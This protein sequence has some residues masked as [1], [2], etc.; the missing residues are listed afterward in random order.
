MGTVTINSI[1]TKSM[2]SV[3]EQFVLLLFTT[4]VSLRSFNYWPTLHLRF[5][6]RIVEVSSH[7]EH[8]TNWQLLFK[9]AED[10]E[11]ECRCKSVKD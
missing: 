6:L 4:A 5:A 11:A 1:S 2:P 9:A 8:R 10:L 7:P 3:C